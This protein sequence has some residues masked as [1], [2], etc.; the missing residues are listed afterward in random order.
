MPMIAAYCTKVRYPAETKLGDTMN[1]IRSW[2]DNKKIKS[3]GFNFERGNDGV[4]SI[5]V[6]FE[7]PEHVQLFDHD[8]RHMDS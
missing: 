2:L 4:L 7:T 5:I 3:A 8:F 1:A 6:S